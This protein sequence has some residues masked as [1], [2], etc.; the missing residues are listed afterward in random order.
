[1]AAYGLCVD[2]ASRILLC[3]IAPGLWSGVGAWTLPGGGLEF[4]EHPRDA[5]VRELHEETGLIGRI[6]AIA[7]V[8]SI[9]GVWTRPDGYVENFH[10]IRIVYRM[11]I[12]GGELTNEIGGSTDLCA[13]LTREEA[14]RMPLV[15]LGEYGVRLAFDPPG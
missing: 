11:T 3:R 15:D 12:T 2:D 8:E 9:S 1:M 13:W 7:G 5:A 10:A 6:E 4:G 14:E